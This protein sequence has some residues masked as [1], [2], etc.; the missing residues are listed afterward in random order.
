MTVPHAALKVYEPLD[1]FEGAERERWTMLIPAAAAT[2]GP[3][4]LVLSRAH[5]LSGAAQGER[6]DVLRF[7]DALYACPHRTRLRLLASL[8]AFRR[9]IP[10]EVAGAF[11]PDGEAERAIRELEALRAEHPD[12]RSH[13]LTSTW[14]VPTRWFVLF[15]EDE[16]IFDAD[17][18]ALAYRTSMVNARRRTGRALDAA[19]QAVIGPGVAAL[20]SELSSWLDLFAEDSVVELDYGG[21]AALIPPEELA[22]DFSA[23]DL[24]TAVSA[25]ADGD[26]LQATTAYMR[27]AE[28]WAPLSALERTN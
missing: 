19:R 10:G 2:R 24:Q 9:T 26:V 7:G 11:M 20:V 18:P 17:T 27:A 3:A 25:L 21:L 14:E 15:D 8:V 1:S 6:A 22:M 28:R 12:W 23:A 16:R 13:I 4:T 5:G